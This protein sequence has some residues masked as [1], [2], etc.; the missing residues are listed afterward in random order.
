MMDPALASSVENALAWPDPVL[1][2]AFA[3]DVVTDFIESIASRRLT[4]A[5]IIDTAKVVERIL[6]LL[7]TVRPAGRRAM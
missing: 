6:H 7:P 4:H 1:D 2:T 3:T 5:E